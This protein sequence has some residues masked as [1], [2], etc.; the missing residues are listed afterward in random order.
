MCNTM[1]KFTF[2]R[3]LVK[4]IFA[5]L[6]IVFAISVQFASA[7]VSLTATAGTTTGSF[8][9]VHDA[10]TAI[11]AGT[12]QGAIVIS[13][14]GNT[15]E[16][17]APAYLAASGQG[18]AAFT[19]VL[20]KPTVIATISGATTAGSAVINL[21]G[22]DNVTIDGSIAVGGT[23][24][25][26]TI[27][28]TA[29]N[30]VGNVACV[31]L[32]GRT[33][34]GLGTSSITIENC[35]I[36]G[37]TTGNNG[38]SGSTQ[39]TTY[40]I[41]A[42]SSVLTTMAATTGG[43]DYDNMII[44]NNSISNAYIGINIIGLTANQ[45]DN[46][47]V[48]NNTI[49]SA[50]NRIG[51]KGFAGQFLVG[52]NMTNNI[53]SD[54]EATSSISVAAIEVGGAATNGFQVRRNTIVDIHNYNAGGY[55]A[56][57]VTI[58][59]GTN[60]VV[61][62]NSITG[63]QTLNYSLST[64]FNAFGIRILGGTGH[65]I[66]YNSV[67][68]YGAYSTGTN[69]TSAFSAALCVTSTAVTGLDIRNNVFA[70]KMTS[71]NPTPEFLAVSF[72]TSYNFANA[73]IERNAYMVTNDAQH[74]VG[75]IGTTIGANNF[76]NLTAWKAISQVNNASN[77]VNSHPGSGNSNAP[78]TSDINLAIPAATVTVLESTG[79][80]V[81]SLGLPNV[82]RT[83]LNRPAFGGSNPDLGAFEFNGSQPGDLVPPVV[84]LVSAAPGAS[85]AAVAHTVT[86][87]ASD[88][89]GVTSVTMNYSYAGVAQTPITMTLATGTALSGTYTA[90]IPAAAG[91]NV[92]VTYSVIAS[93]AGTNLSPVISGSPYT[94]N[95][96]VVTA[97]ADQTINSGNATSVSAT[98][99]DPSFGRLMISEVVQF[100]GGT[101]DGTY[102][103][104]IPTTDNDFVELVNFGNV[105]M[106]AGGYKLNIYGAVNGSYTIPA[107]TIIPSG[108]TLVLAF[109]GTA[110]DV[111]N[112]Y[113]GM[114]LGVTT[115]STV[116]NGYVLRD[117]QGTIKDAVALNN[118]TFTGA[119]GVTATDWSGT[120]PNSSAGVRRTVGTDNNVATDWT[121]SSATNLMNIGVYNTE[122]TIV[123]I[124]LTITWTN[125][126]NATTSTLNPLPVAAF[127]TA[128]TYTFYATFNDGTCTSVDSVIITVLTPIAPVAN[129]SATPL[130]I[131]AGSN[132]T[133]TDLSTN[134]P[135]SWLWSVSPST[136]VTYVSGTTNAS[137]NPVM[138]FAN[139]GVYSVT[140]TAT[141]AVGSDDTTRLQY[142][143]VSFCA[144]GATNAA[145]TDLGNVTFGALNNGSALPVFSNPAAVGLY[146]DFTSLPVQTFNLGQT[147][148]ISL[149]QITSGAT[150][151]SAYAN[152]FIDFNNDGSFDPLT[153]RVFNAATSNTG[154]ISTVTGNVTIPA[155]AFIGN[156]RMRVIIDESGSASSAPCGTF[157]YGETED[158]II[159]IACPT[160]TTTTVSACGSYVWAENGQTYTS[161]GTYTYAA[162]TC[163]PSTLNLTINTNSFATQTASACGSYVWALNGSTY[164]ASGSYVDTIPSSSGCDSI[165][166]LNLTINQA[167]SATQSATACGSYL[168]ALNGVTYS[169]SGAFV[170]TILNSVGCDSIVTLNLTINQS[171]SS[172]VATTSC[173]SY[174]WVL[175]GVTYSAS[176][177]YVDT[178]V[179]TAGCD[180]IV[181]LN[182][183]INQ[184]TSSSL[185]VASCDSY[186]WAQNGMTYTASGA[187][188]DTIP[189]AAGCDSIVTLN[190]TINILNLT[191]TNASPT[192][193]SNEVGATYQWLDCG[194]GNA[195]ISGA[196]AAIYV[197]T[198]N[199][200]YA[201]EVT[202]NNCIDTSV[203]EI[204][205]NVGLDKLNNTLN[206]VFSPNPTNDF[207][208][209]DFSTVNSANVQVIDAT[210]KVVIPQ[211][212]INSGEKLDLRNMERGVYFVKISSLGGNSIERIVKN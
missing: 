184:A 203:C 72:P 87:T 211:M 205:A 129:F 103:A 76:S 194:N 125:S 49:G 52:G 104:Y 168:W 183:T 47:Q 45:A 198:A 158:Y 177:A 156:V 171:T 117:P 21:D 130:T 133:Y 208:R 176:G 57:G 83:N 106:N 172:S 174:T 207:V 34:L 155:T 62:N 185:T 179:N 147:Y 79:L 36:I 56:Y 2:Y 124:P 144:S 142:I 48:L 139:A 84:S 66:Y 93:D 122:I 154:P 27:Q 120:I 22:A 140:L 30:T 78:F 102:P 137:Q 54:I 197:A 164:S 8:L 116:Q 190:L 51:F 55:G 188:V 88:N 178:L 74:F 112:L 191:V 13:I 23:T 143:T 114:N 70:N 187:Y 65:Q 46:L 63:V 151:Y 206:V 108:A 128:G 77:D 67:N 123:A 37:S 175:N 199:G 146:T 18:L 26:L 200:S 50:T 181:T 4:P 12:H 182:L 189:N 91:P 44:R 149:S 162:G 6:A 14:N 157:S 7:Q 99:N 9:T 15:T 17:A 58:L 19:S 82:D 96:L 43:A 163:P 153:E 105:A 119:S 160:P 5:S 159:N 101:G 60:V 132:V 121:I 42:G 61:A 138:Q 141:N 90:I 145:D 169:T 212:E 109:T 192:L 95:Y 16:P 152:V 73:N 161:S 11:N 32:I 100:K 107:N 33:T 69:T 31:R 113:F 204:V 111:T 118:Y 81:V 25:D 97:S 167:S 3:V 89:V 165:V 210:G 150:F 68:M 127:A 85:C 71:T 202:K 170:D 20:I 115:S 196:T 136:G 10:F 86:A 28:N 80:P 39:T 53:V 98:A 180:S 59:T 135:S 92:L 195:A 35:N 40:G 209:V 41:Y 64:T 24:R 1:K 29:A 110:A 94:D 134:I 193:T 75:K 201:V 166:T 126:F 148:P 38:L 173:G 131:A 186:T